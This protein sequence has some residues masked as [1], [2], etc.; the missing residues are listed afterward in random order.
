[1]RMHIPVHEWSGVTWVVDGLASA[2]NGSFFSFFNFHKT[3]L[4]YFCYIYNFFFFFL[5]A[6]F[7]SVLMDIL[8]R[9]SFALSFDFDQ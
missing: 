9:D 2:V 7:C 8:L 6:K 1:M 5:L 3:N 4:L